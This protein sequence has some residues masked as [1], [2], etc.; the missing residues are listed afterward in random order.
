MKAII[1]DPGASA[2]G[3]SREPIP[4]LD[5]FDSQRSWRMVAAAFVAMFAVYGVAYSFGA[6]FK[7]MAAEFGA[8]SWAQVFL[9]FVLAHPAVTCVIPAT[10]KF[11][12]L[13]D[14]L[15]AGM[16]PLPTPK[17]CA[18]IVAALE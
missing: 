10:G 2:A 5:L 13:A 9:K 14:N 18:Q 3:E 1:T 15:S 11:R 17:Q 7:P 4:S 16:G 8:K 6:F 12:N